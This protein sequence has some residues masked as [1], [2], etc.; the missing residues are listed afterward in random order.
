MTTR[1]HLDRW[2]SLIYSGV[3]SDA[4]DQAGLRHQVARLDARPIRGQ[5]R[6]LVGYARPVRAAAVSAIP[7]RPYEPEVA[8][9]DSLTSGDVVVATTGGS[10]SGFWGELFSTAAVGRGARGAVVDGLVR[11]QRKILDLE[12]GV[13]A[14][15]GGPADS[16]GRLSIVEQDQPIEFGGVMVAR[17]DLVV[18][19]VDGIVIVP[20]AAVDDVIEAALA[21]A[22]TENKARD[23]L[24]KGGLLADV[25][26]RFQVL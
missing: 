13:F 22:S 9:V 23:L 20:A 24:L 17:D 3:V 18:A 25:W 5:D 11:D 2:A 10:S 8:Y 15:G 26:E 14:T 4:C 1:Q 16:L 12:F 6:V 19:D 21:K 7:D